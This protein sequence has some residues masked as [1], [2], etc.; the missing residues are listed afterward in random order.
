MNHNTAMQSDYSDHQIPKITK[1]NWSDI[2]SEDE[3]RNLSKSLGSFN[4]IK[5]NFFRIFRN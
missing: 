1:I 5:K 4:R 3:L 2:S